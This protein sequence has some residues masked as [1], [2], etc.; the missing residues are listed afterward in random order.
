MQISS[1]KK[2]PRKSL[3]IIAFVCCEYHAKKT[4]QPERLDELLRIWNGFPD[5]Y[6]M[7]TCH[8][9]VKLWLFLRTLNY[10]ERENT[11]SSALVQYSVKLENQTELFFLFCH[12]I[13]PL[14]C[15]HQAQYPA[16]Y[17]FPIKDLRSWVGWVGCPFNQD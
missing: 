16:V 9:R 11:K 7:V 10:Q 4:T 6:L 12:C 1:K 2:L 17:N 3:K 5:F 14:H 15:W 13:A 8:I